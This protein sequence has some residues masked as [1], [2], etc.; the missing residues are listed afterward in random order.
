MVQFWRV[1]VQVW[2]SQNLHALEPL[3]LPQT[4]T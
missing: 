3:R 4:D 2:L 1:V